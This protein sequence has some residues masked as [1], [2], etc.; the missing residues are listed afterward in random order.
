M[1]GRAFVNNRL[2]MVDATFK[3]GHLIKFFINKIL[4]LSKLNEKPSPVNPTKKGIGLK[5][6]N[7]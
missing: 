5:L 7:V 6:N 1:M 2:Y 3:K 4:D